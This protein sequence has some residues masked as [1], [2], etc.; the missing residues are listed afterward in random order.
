LVWTILNCQHL[1]NPTTISSARHSSHNQSLP[2]S[3]SNVLRKHPDGSTE[4]TTRLAELLSKHSAGTFDP[5]NRAV[6]CRMG[7][8]INSADS[9]NCPGDSSTGGR[10]EYDWT[11]SGCQ[12][13][14]Q[15]EGSSER[16]SNPVDNDNNN[17]T[18]STYGSL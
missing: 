4:Y 18:K 1:W 3:L 5:S 14:D 8:N 10:I 2:D 9:G 17:E 15:P 11:T 12:F 6:E 7:V 13:G 16:A